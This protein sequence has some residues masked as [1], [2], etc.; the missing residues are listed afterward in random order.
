MLF[1]F[2]FQLIELIKQYCSSVAIFF[3]L[4]KSEY[5]SSTSATTSLVCCNHCIG[6]FWTSVDKCHTE[7]CIRVSWPSGTFTTA[8]SSKCVSKIEPFLQTEKWN[9]ITNFTCTFSMA[10]GS[11]LLELPKS[12]ACTL[13]KKLAERWYIPEQVPHWTL[14][15]S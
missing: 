3:V 13:K 14:F 5:E 10:A 12:Q 9:E 6:H 11:V 8:D 1:L 2:F 7:V 15:M 4:I